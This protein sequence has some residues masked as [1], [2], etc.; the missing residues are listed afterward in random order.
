MFMLYYIYHSN[1]KLQ[2]R[3][4]AESSVQ[5]KALINAKYTKTENTKP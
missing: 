5:T 1:C 2:I 4:A 3:G